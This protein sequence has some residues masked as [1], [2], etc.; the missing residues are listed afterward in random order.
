MPYDEYL[1]WMHRI[2]HESRRIL[3]SDGSFF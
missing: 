3:R 2:A 1:D